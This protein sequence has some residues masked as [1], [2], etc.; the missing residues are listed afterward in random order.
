MRERTRSERVL[1]DL[2][3]RKAE[4]A[5]GYTATSKTRY[6]APNL[7]GGHLRDGLWRH[8]LQ[9]LESGTKL[10][11]SFRGRNARIDW[12]LILQL[13]QEMVHD[14]PEIA[15]DRVWAF[16]TEEMPR[17]ARLLRRAKMSPPSGRGPDQG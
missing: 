4:A 14:Y 11:Q 5:A 16:A 9:F 6:D 10:G 17:M 3:L 7:E 2:M 12:D 8:V 1:V 13:R 15:P